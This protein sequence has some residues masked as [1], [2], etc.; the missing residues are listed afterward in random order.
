M[1][2]I[3]LAIINLPI[4]DPN[5][6]TDVSNTIIPNRIYTAFQNPVFLRVLLVR[7]VAHVL[8]SHFKTKTTV[9]LVFIVFTIFVLSFISGYQYWYC[10]ICTSYIE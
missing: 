7:L 3:A 1:Y 5:S 9:F 2:G 4:T 6:S 10:V 8:M